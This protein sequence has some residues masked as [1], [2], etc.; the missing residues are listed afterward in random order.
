MKLKSF[1]ALCELLSK[2]CASQIANVFLDHNNASIDCLHHLRDSL[3]LNTNICAIN[4]REDAL[5]LRE[6]SI[7]IQAIHS[8]LED[9][10]RDLQVDGIYPVLSDLMKVFRL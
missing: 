5:A 9:I 10:L 1:S 2:N 4:I 8:H 3:K 7:D 6:K